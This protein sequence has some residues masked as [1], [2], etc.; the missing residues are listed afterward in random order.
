MRQTTVSDHAPDQ[1]LTLGV[2]HS[3]AACRLECEMTSDAAVMS[4]NVSRGCPQNAHI[5]TCDICQLPMQVVR[6]LLYHM[7]R[8]M[9]APASCHGS[10]PVSPRMQLGEFKRYEEKLY[11]GDR[12]PAS[13]LGNDDDKPRSKCRQPSVLNL[14]LG[15]QKTRCGSERCRYKHPNACAIS[16]VQTERMLELQR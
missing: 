15:A 13:R 11:E 1:P 14:Q 12:Y 7:P 4:H 9:H 6:M 5:H 2:P 16:P 3:L 8:P 10:A